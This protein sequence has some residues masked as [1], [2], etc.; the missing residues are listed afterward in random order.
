M[1]A[2][3]S[4]E[5][6]LGATMGLNLGASLFQR[7]AALQTADAI[8]AAAKYNAKLAERQGAREEARLRRKA[9]LQLSSQALAFN[10][11][12]VEIT[13]SALEFLASNASELE[14][15]AVNARIDAQATARLERS[16][17]ESA[18]TIGEQRA[19]AALL[20]GL[21]QSSVYGLSLLGERGR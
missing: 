18:Q 13:G 8:S 21:T 20:S 12:G 19:G 9:K 3:L 11:A 16:R 10:K 5:D 7:K 6:L 14:R 4:S 1:G 17:A 2:V 15:D